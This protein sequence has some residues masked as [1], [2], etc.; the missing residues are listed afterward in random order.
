MKYNS[1]L[2]R[3]K[4][5]ELLNIELNIKTFGDLLYYFPTSILTAQNFILL[6]RSVPTFHISS[7]RKDWCHTLH[8]GQEQKKADRGIFRWYRNTWADLVPG[9]NW[10]KDSLK[11]GVDY[12]VFGKPTCM[13]GKSTLSTLSWRKHQS[14]K[15]RYLRRFRHIMVQQRKLKRVIWLRGQFK[16]YC[17][18]L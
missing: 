18:P 4:R 17:Q 11:P 2:C 7:K 12:I 16:T 9:V 8:R 15:V 14:T 3:S 6:M 13:E 10:I 5:A 1:F